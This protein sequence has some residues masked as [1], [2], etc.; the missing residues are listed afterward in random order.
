MCIILTL[1][2]SAIVL[3]ISILFSMLSIWLWRSLYLWEM[4][5]S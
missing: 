3:W 4:W 5:S 2:S 1:L